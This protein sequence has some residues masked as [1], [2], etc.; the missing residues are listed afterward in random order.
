VPMAP[1]A[2]FGQRGIVCGSAWKVS[3]ARDRKVGREIMFFPDL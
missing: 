3:N 1:G 2:P